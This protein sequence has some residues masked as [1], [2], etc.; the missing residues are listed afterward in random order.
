MPRKKTKTK[1]KL[2]TPPYNHAAKRF[3]TKDEW[4]KADWSA[5]RKAKRE[6]R[7]AASKQAKKQL[8]GPKGKFAPKTPKKSKAA[9]EGA[10]AAMQAAAAAAALAD[11]SVETVWVEREHECPPC[12]PEFPGLYTKVAQ[13]L[14][15][16]SS[17]VAEIQK[18]IAEMKARLRLAPQRPAANPIETLAIVNRT[19]RPEGVLSKL[20]DSAKDNPLL[21]LAAIA[22]AIFAGY[23][24][25]RTM[26]QRGESQGG[27][28]VAGLQMPSE[29]PTGLP[30]GDERYGTTKPGV[31]PPSNIN[32]PNTEPAFGDDKD[33]EGI[34]S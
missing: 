31:E 14:Q 6:G 26:R 3:K 1:K 10:A 33:G 12:E 29:Q 13:P 2:W 22:A 20:L 4:T 7:I 30:T 23:M 8:R 25:Y 32:L 24:L 34:F 15:M 21:A 27:D 28:L 16:T 17:Q 9:K 19:E 18:D 11:P 5:Y